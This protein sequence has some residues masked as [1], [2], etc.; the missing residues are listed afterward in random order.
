MKKTFSEQASASEPD[1]MLPEYD[2]DYRKA[3]P[4]RFAERVYQDRR[5]VILDPDI[6]EVFTTSDSVNTVLRALLAT[7]PKSEIVKKSR[8]RAAKSGASRV[9]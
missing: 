1:D 3:R 8:K 4:N 5:V 7:M 2:F 9:D 6:S